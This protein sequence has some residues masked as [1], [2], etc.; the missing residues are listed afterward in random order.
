MKEK[1]IKSLDFI[2]RIIIITALVFSNQKTNHSLDANTLVMYGVLF[3]YALAFSLL[4]SNRWVILSEIVVV[5]SISQYFELNTLY[6]ILPVLV[7]KYLNL[8]TELYDYAVMI[9]LSSLFSYYRTTDPFLMCV[10]ALGTIVLIL[11]FV[12]KNERIDYM[13]SELKSERKR[14]SE[15]KTEIFE[16]KR[17][18]ESASR[19]AE[20]SRRL[21]EIIK[22][23]DIIDRMLEASKWI[24]HAE[25]VCLYVKSDRF[26]KLV[27][28]L[29]DGENYSIPQSL[30]PKD[31][32]TLLIEQRMMR[33]PIR[34]GD[35]KWGTLV[36]FNKRSEVGGKQKIPFPF[37]EGD[38]EILS[39]YISQVMLQ[40]KNAKAMKEIR[41]LANND[42][43]TGIPNRAYFMRQAE[44]LFERAKR[45][46]DLTIFI[47]D[48][49]NFKKFND[50]Y[51]HH[52]GDEVLKI[53]ANTI[54]NSVRKV[55]VVARYGGEEFAIV[56]P[57]AK[58]NSQIVAERIRKKIKSTKFLETITVS[59]GVSHFGSGGKSVSEILNTADKAL[60]RAKNT[61][62][63][64]VVY[65]KEGM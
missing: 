11:S 48:V 22:L 31:A 17:E 60:Y 64:K 51:G 20:Q 16:Q 61:G 52:T 10:A 14:I 2:Y 41:D 7:A 37:E 39:I 32:E 24:F 58:D 3:I 18:L 30:S 44:Y 27:K 47:L 5:L 12:N 23:D 40:M 1:L 59:I 42:S 63:D 19:M 4:K 6:F 62:K 35:K 56:L 38:Y 29:G 33:M 46:E 45:G 43:L 36:I 9:I 53:V 49:D 21:T 8:K 15:Y 55:D 26:Y 34:Y 50:K 28:E 13:E 54:K 65:Y 25:Y 57:N